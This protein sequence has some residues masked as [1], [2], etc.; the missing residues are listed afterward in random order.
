MKLRLL[1][2]KRQRMFVVAYSAWVVVLAVLYWSERY[3]VEGQWS[4]FKWLALGPLLAFL[5]LSV[6]DCIGMGMDGY[7]AL[8]GW[9]NRGA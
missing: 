5:V 4:S 6:R 1:R 3:E 9:I 8:R 2:T 7:R